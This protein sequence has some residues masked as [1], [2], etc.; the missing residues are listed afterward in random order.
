MFRLTL[1][2]GRVRRCRGPRRMGLCGTFVEGGDEFVEFAREGF[3][4]VAAVAAF[5]HG[6]GVLQRVADFIPLGATSLGQH[7]F[8]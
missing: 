3:E 5:D 2:P 4:A 6:F 1:R 8:E 7:E